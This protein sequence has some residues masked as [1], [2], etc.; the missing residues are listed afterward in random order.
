MKTRNGNLSRRSFT[1]VE[2]LVV[3]GIIAI[4]AGIL[5]P[6]LNSARVSA[7]RANCIS[8]Q[9]QTMKFISSSMATDDQRFVSGA[10]HTATGSDE[11]WVYWLIN[12]NRVADLTALRCPSIVCTSAADGANA[13]SLQEA[14]GVAFATKS[15]TLKDGSSHNGFDFRGTKLLTYD[16]SGSKTMISPAALV[17]GSCA[18]LEV[19]NEFKARSVV[20]FGDSV[21][22]TA[23]NYGFSSDQHGGFTNIFCFDGHSESVN[24]D[25]YATKYYPGYSG[26]TPQALKIDADS[27]SSPDEV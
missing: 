26:S 5:L 16:P 19:S 11:S 21:N 27:W 7:K 9:G 17:L 13:A 12:K 10:T 24:K 22:T 6:S 8:N 4:L 15:I 23:G 14:Y 20:K 25:A 1:M 2:L 18:A 3:I